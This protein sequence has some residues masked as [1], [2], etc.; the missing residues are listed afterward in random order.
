[1][2]MWIISRGVVLLILLMEY[3]PFISSTVSEDKRG[4]ALFGYQDLCFRQELLEYINVHDND[5]RE[6][7]TI[8]RENVTSDLIDFD[9]DV[10]MSTSRGK[11]KLEYKFQDKMNSE[12]IFS[13]GSALEDFISVVFVHDGNIVSYPFAPDSD[14]PPLRS[15][16]LWKKTFYEET[17][18]ID[19]MTELPKSQPKKTYKENLE[20]E[21][22]MVKI[23]RCMAWLGSTNAYDEP[24]GIQTA[25]NLPERSRRDF[26]KPIEVEPLNETQL[27]DLGLNTCNHEIPLSSREVPSFD[28][29]EPQPKTLANCP[30][31][32]ASL[33]DK[34]GLEPSI[35]PHSPDSFRMKEVDNLTNH[36]PPSLSPP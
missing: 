17:H 14:E 24:I 15:Y 33:E 13:F 34:R 9:V 11:S 20:S 29:P 4:N 28:E 25:H 30:Y 1:M 31:L 12:D 7:A 21:I 16:Q 27:E 10:T 35:K 5:I 2:P 18:K 8:M 32:D 26:R 22:V 3:K 19:D 23:P 6:F 36:T